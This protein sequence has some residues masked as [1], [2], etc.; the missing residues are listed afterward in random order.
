MFLEK[1]FGEQGAARNL[2]GVVATLTFA[3]LWEKDSS[4]M[5]ASEQ[6][7]RQ[8]VYV[9]AGSTKAGSKRSNSVDAKAGQKKNQPV[10]WVALMEGR[11][12]I[13]D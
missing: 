5:A 2:T 11:S 8:P 13:V 12:S 4:W 3:E 6:E 10:E 9:K 7:K 1:P